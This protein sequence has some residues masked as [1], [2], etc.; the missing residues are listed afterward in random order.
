MK[1]NGNHA[2]LAIQTNCIM[3]GNKLSWFFRAEALKPLIWFGNRLWTCNVKAIWPYSRKKQEVAR[4]FGVAWY[5]TN[6]S[7]LAPSSPKNKRCPCQFTRK[8]KMVF[9][10]NPLPSIPSHLC[11]AAVASHW[12]LAG[13]WHTPIGLGSYWLCLTPRRSPVMSHPFWQA[14]PP[15]SHCM[16]GQRDRGRG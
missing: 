16:K 9:T 3:G 12:P 11:C 7:E 2:Q 1:A 15:T 8:K 6:H 10:H 13:W 5:V 14:P 4:H